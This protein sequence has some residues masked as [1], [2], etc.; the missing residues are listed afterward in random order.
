MRH[1][2][3][4]ALFFF[5]GTQIA[6]AQDAV[7]SSKLAAS[8]PVGRVQLVEDSKN[9][10]LLILLEGKQIARCRSAGQRIDCEVLA[11]DSAIVLP[12]EAIPDWDQPKLDGGPR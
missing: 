4:V 6:H 5:I 10:A 3:L 1:V 9:G 7:A 12:A 11:P 2:F 8:V